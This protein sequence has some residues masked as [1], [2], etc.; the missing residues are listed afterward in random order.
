[1]IGNDIVD[2][3]IDEKK[4]LNQR[5][6]KRILTQTEAQNLAVA[7][8]KNACLWSLWAAKEAIY[9]CLQ[10]AQHE[11]IFSPKKI[12]LEQQ[13]LSL[14]NKALSKKSKQLSVFNITGSHYKVM[15]LHF[16]WPDST[17]VHCTAVQ[18]MSASGCSENL[19][20]T[21]IHNTNKN[22]TYQQQSSQVRLLAQQLLIENHIAAQIKRPDLIMNGYSKPGPP[23][24][25]DEN[26]Q[27][28]DHQI[29]LSHDHSWLAVAVLKAE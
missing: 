21:K 18:Q 5:F 4:Y 12:Q 27:L 24:L 13:V 6:I 20:K 17:T 26:N 28:L 15:D 2:F 25:L 14:L 1:M 7:K 22:L 9:K 16:S 19:L 23:V 3:E 29:S 11:L 8:D 10:R